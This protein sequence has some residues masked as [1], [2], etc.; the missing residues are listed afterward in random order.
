VL[1]VQQKL[2]L[3]VL[4]KWNSSFGVL[5]NYRNS[6]NLNDA[7]CS[8]ALPEEVECSLVHV[9]YIQNLSD[10]SS[11]FFYRRVM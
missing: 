6:L 10:I 7:W 2:N 11:P 4:F 9:H 5:I 8:V 1:C 3:R